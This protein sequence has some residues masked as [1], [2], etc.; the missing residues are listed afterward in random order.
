MPTYVIGDVH[1]CYDLLLRLEALIVADAAR[2][3]GRKLIVMLGDYVDRGPSSSRVI[4]H[5]MDP[6]PTGF[7][8][9]CLTGNHEIAMVDYIDGK[10]SLTDWLGLGADA[11]LAS[12]GMEPAQLAKHYPTPKKLDAYIRKSLPAAH[13]AFM[14]ELPILLDTPDAL[15]VHA[16]IDP[17]LPISE[18]GDEELIY[19]RGRFFESPLPLPKLII[20]GHTP[21]ETPHVHGLG[22]N[23]DTGACWSGVLTAA[24]L[25]QGHVHI[26]ST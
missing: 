25:W 7:D 21:V 6:P 10:I 18:Q 12:Y 24:R 8:R 4:S 17:S 20:H 11:T 13:I 5:L 1:G 26:S 19:I 9:V 22:L 2:L 14:R 3:P 23:I 15:F 16:G